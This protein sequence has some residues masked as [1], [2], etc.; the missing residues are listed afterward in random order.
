MAAAMRRS[1]A[2]KRIAAT[3]GQTRVFCGQV[4]SK[5]SRSQCFFEPFQSLS[6]KT[7]VMSS[8]KIRRAS[9]VL[10]P[11]AGSSSTWNLKKIRKDGKPVCL[12]LV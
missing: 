5:L 9:Q 10:K 3:D 4:G 2:H 1:K 8:C 7:A 6:F 12:Q 11:I